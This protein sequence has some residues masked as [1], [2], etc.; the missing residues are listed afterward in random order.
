MQPSA[1]IRQLPQQLGLVETPK[2][3][4]LHSQMTAHHSDSPEFKELATRYMQ[5]AAEIVEAKPQ[6]AEHSRAQIALTVAMALIR[7][8][9]GQAD[10]YVDELEEARLQ[11]ANE[12]HDDVLA[13]LDAAIDEALTH[14]D[15]LVP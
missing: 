1:S 9:S 10:Y 14:K 15:D 12:G 11:A 13:I 5:L 4:Q 7:L 8:D 6:G 2:L 3:R